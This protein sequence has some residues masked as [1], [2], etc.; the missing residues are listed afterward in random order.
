MPTSDPTKH[1]GNPGSTVPA[2]MQAKI[3]DLC[4]QGVTRNDIHRQTGVANSS[5]SGIVKRA[6][7][8]FDRTRIAAAAKA[9]K[10]DRSERR[11]RII[12]RGYR[13]IE[14]LQDRLEADT[15]RTMQKDRGGGE[16]PVELKFVPTL[17]EKNLATTISSY[18]GTV[19]NLEKLDAGDASN[20]VKSMLA[21]LGRALGITAR[22]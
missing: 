14:A 1:Y 22:D 19:T 17:D 12:D 4:R 18:V 3:L 5:I 8:T 7:L 16:F 13:R 2:E 15:F 11:A 6:G 21:E 20:D 10:A 9:L